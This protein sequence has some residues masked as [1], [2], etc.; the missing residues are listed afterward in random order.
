MERGID[1]NGYI[2]F[3]SQFETDASN[4]RLPIIQIEKGLRFRM[5]K[6]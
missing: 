2:T 1:A 3:F 5:V 4:I 6:W